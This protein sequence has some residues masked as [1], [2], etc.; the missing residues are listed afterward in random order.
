MG[1][2]FW[3]FIKK[4]HVQY[5]N[6]HQNLKMIGKSVMLGLAV[7]GYAAASDMM[8][9][10]T[11]QQPATT[12]TTYQQPMSANERTNF[13]NGRSIIPDLEH[14]YTTGLL[15]SFFLVLGLVLILDLMFSSA[16]ILSALSLVTNLG[17]DDIGDA[18]ARNDQEILTRKVYDALNK[19]MDP[20]V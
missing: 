11:F 15:M 5:S 1:V 6:T 9:P 20:Y 14:G 13:G 18:L 3:L 19:F 7:A 2:I 10:P 12:Y 8:Q 17:K 16:N 4:V